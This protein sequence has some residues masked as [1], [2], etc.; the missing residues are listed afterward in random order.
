MP[1]GL[2]GTRNVS[3][4]SVAPAAS[5]EVMPTAL[6]DPARAGGGHIAQ[7]LHAEPVIWLGTVSATGR[8]HAVPVWYWWAD[9]VVTIFCDPTS[10]KLAH[11]RR[12]AAVGVWL[13]TAAHGTDVI[14][15]EGTARE[16]ALAEVT[17]VVDKF[18]TKYAAMLG[19]MPIAAWLQQFS[20]PVAVTL[21]R[22]MA[23]RRDVSGALDYQSFPS[24]PA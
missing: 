23:W 10:A 2:R 9:P 5:F 16:H 18:A 19:G 11:L 6:I 3:L 13:D 7:R 14:L 21:E 12:S 24:P 4:V 15:G 1:T 20:Q 8:P 17:G 22:L